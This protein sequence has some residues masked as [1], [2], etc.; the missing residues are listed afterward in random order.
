MSDC[1]LCQHAVELLLDFGPQPLCNRFLREPTAA[2]VR[3]PLRLGQCPRCGVLQLVEPL[4]AAVLKPPRPMLYNEPE[5]HLDQV[6]DR[7]ETLPGISRDARFCG[8]TYKEASLIAR[9]RQ[10][11]YRNAVSLDV[12]EDLGI[13]DAA[14]GIETIQQQISTGVLSRLAQHQGRYQVVVARHLLEHAHDPRSCVV[15]LQGLLASDGYLI[16]EVPDFTASLEGWNYSTIWEEHVTYFTK[17]TFPAALPRLGLAVRD[18]LTHPSALEDLLVGVTQVAAQKQDKAFEASVS[19]ELVRGCRYASMFPEIREA[20]REM[21]VG[22]RRTGREVALLGA[23]HLAIMFLNLLELAPF[24]DFIVDDDSAK[25]GCHLP[26]S[27]L[28]VYSS[29]ALY[30]R[31]VGLCLMS[32]APE[33]QSKVMVRHRR[34]LEREGKLVSIFAPPP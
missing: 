10:R 2:E 13:L 19:A 33:S 6:A 4:P 18:L 30:D 14:A 32:V 28:P 9:L 31:D 12:R 17:T 5:S 15:G 24:V 22:E 27:H 21:L 25:T 3:H 16:L 34:F 23:G 7:I 20:W 8:L 1:R 11:G 29:D 26:G